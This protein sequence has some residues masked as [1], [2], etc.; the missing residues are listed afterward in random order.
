MIDHAS[1]TPNDPNDIAPEIR[2]ALE[3]CLHLPSPPGIALKILDLSRDP[4]VDLPTLAE[5]I[6]KDPALASRLLRA[7]HSSLF[8]HRPNPTTNL[9]HAMVVLGLR[10]TIT[11][12]LSFSLAHDFQEK[13]DSSRNLVQI[14]R[15]A[16]ISASAARLLGLRI[17]YPNPETL[18]LAALLQDIGIL[19]LHS[20]IPERYDPLLAHFVDHDSLLVQERQMLGTDHGVAGAW[21]MRRW[22]LPESLAIVAESVHQIDLDHVRTDSEKLLVH[23]VAIAGKLADFFLTQDHHAHLAEDLACDADERLGLK[24]QDL[25]TL[26][27]QVAELLPDIA[28]I[29]ATEVISE[30]AAEEALAQAQALLAALNDQ[31]IR[32]ATERK[33]YLRNMEIA[34]TQ[35]PNLKLTTTS[36][37]FHQ[38]QRFAE[39]LEQQWTESTRDGWPLTLAFVDVE[40]LDTINA[41]HG[42]GAGDSVLEALLHGL[43]AQTG[44]QSAI[45]HYGEDE[46]LV[47]LPHTTLDE[48]T[49]L[50]AHLRE[51]LT[52]SAAGTPYR[53]AFAVGLASHG[54]DGTYFPHAQ[55]LL[56]AAGHA[57]YAA[58][59]NHVHHNQAAA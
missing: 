47:L 56:R 54:D 45:T 15:R 32:D 17:G 31:L 42:R 41:Q 18:F 34:A 23:C 25:Q 33:R 36:K 8:N 9:Q 12:A 14:W 39:I 48:G 10:A 19:A 57:L 50:F 4:E 7:S 53:Y 46:F 3:C 26:M 1:A 44:E 6:A 21:L 49:M 5:W 58:K 52:N 51:T 37:R 30:A 29:Y 38:R 28:A 55:A 40:H 13:T 16:L 2:Q 35:H 22:G 11:L 27:Q 24:A 43:L 20:A 59:K